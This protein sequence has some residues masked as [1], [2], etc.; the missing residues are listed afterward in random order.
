[1]FKVIF[2]FIV[3]TLFFTFSVFSKNYEKIIV[4]GNDRISD[5]TI[6][7]FSEITDDRILNESLINEI[8]KKLYKSGFFK[9]VNVK[10]ENNNLI[11]NVIE[12]PIIQTVFIKGIKRKKTEESLYEIL[13]LKD[14]SSYN[15]SSV[16]KDENAILNYLKEEGYY[17]SKITSSY[18]DLGDNKIDLF[19]QVEL[20]DKAKI[21]K[22]S[23]IG[24]KKFKDSILKNVIVSEEYRFWKFISGK[25]Y[26][27]ENLINYDKR[28]LNN[29]FKNRGFFNVKI[30]SSFANY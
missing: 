19:Y 1:M 8:L 3:F 26:L 22:I 16:N 6:L 2:Q 4:N 7:V 12:N 17:F 29:F 21:S 28:L 30:G 27:N 25:K 5:E 9:D 15:L 20:G 24:D 18:Q 23:F 13:S 10:L 11:I 14:R